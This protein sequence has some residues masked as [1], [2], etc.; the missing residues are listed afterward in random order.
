MYR[1]RYQNIKGQKREEK[2]ES[3]CK[4]HINVRE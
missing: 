3:K 2:H 4:I 1:N